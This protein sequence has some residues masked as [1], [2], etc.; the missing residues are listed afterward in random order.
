MNR[1]NKTLSTCLLFALSLTVA[2]DGS[3]TPDGSNPPPNPCGSCASY[4]QC[5]PSG[6][7]GVS[8]N[9]S[10][11]LAVTRAQ[12]A[13]TKT[14]G[15]AWDVFGGAPDPFVII[16]TRR[17]TTVSDSF[18]PVWNEGA[19]YTAATLL[20]QGV[21]VEVLDEDSAA[22]DSIGG[23]SKVTFPEAAFRSGILTVSNF[24]QAQQLS[25]SLT[26]R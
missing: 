19:T 10:W 5:L 3:S 25:F 14:T 2:C 21:T 11:F 26:P 24:G 20:G 6:S 7:C 22:N 18:T 4:E 16:D 8:P 23:P 9:S 15:D 12:I 17:T 13:S 1:T